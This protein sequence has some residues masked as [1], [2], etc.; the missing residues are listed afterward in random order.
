MNALVQHRP[1]MA[2]GVLAFVVHVLFLILLVFGVSWQ[3]HNPAPVMVDL[4][5]EL[6]VEPSPLPKPQAA[7]VEPAPKPKLEPV[8]RPIPPKPVEQ[9]KVKAPDIALEKK[10][11]ADEEKIRKTAEEAKKRKQQELSL[12]QEEARQLE[13]E[14]MREQ[15]RL[16][17]EQ[18]HQE[19][20]KSLAEKKRLENMK[21]EEDE[22][23]KRMMDEALASDTNQLKALEG[24]AA[25]DRRSAELGRIVADFR[26]KIRAK[27]RG[28]TRI[29]DNLKGNPQSRF[30]V[31][32]L[33]TGEIVSVKLIKSSGNTAY[34]QAVE[35]AIYKS[36]PLPTPTDKD[37]VAQFRKLDLKF[38]PKE[39]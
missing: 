16:E 10:K 6:P 24:K 9:P 29:P 35:R 8:P 32:V 36:S 26:E 20:E 22:M 33:P 7:P 27:I 21:R 11:K 14:T 13:L 37:A 15:A 4:W 23:Q 17:S 30:E 3:I 1:E 31:N 5:S 12:R 19:A 18:K 28:N 38:Q 2:A 25:A 39:N 34:D